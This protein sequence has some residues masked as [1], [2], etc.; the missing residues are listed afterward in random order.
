MA[1]VE[2]HE[3]ANQAHVGEAPAISYTPQCRMISAKIHRPA[4]TNP[5]DK[6]P[7]ILGIQCLIAWDLDKRSGV[8]KLVLTLPLE[9]QRLLCCH[10]IAPGS[11]TGPLLTY[12]LSHPFGS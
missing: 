10:V 4:D 2:D 7:W 11:K 1:P 8:P 9:P 12:S 3:L 5:M 6:G